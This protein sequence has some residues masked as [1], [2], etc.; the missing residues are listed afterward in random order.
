MSRLPNAQLTL[1][2]PND[3][4]DWVDPPD[5]VSDA[6]DEL[7]DRI[8]DPSGAWVD[9]ALLRGS[10]TN[11][12]QGTG[13]LVDDSDNVTAI[14]SITAA[15]SAL[16]KAGGTSGAPAS[17]LGAADLIASGGGSAGLTGGS[18]TAVGGAVNILGGAGTTRGGAVIVTGGAGG[19]VNGDGGDVVLTPGAAAGSGT[20]AEVI[21]KDHGGTEALKITNAATPVVEFN[22]DLD[23]TSQDIANA[24]IIT[25]ASTLSLLSA[26]GNNALSVTGGSNSGGTGGSVGITAGSSTGSG[27]DGGTVTLTAGG[28][29]GGGTEGRIVL[30]DHAGTDALEVT[31]DILP[32]VTCNRVLT[33]TAGIILPTTQL[34]GPDGNNNIGFVTDTSAITKINNVTALTVTGTAHDFHSLAVSNFEHVFPLVFGNSTQ[35]SADAYDQM[36]DSVAC[37]AVRGYMIPW[38]YTIVAV[39]CVVNIV[40]ATSGDVT[41]EIRI[42]DAT[43][44]T[45]E[46]QYTSAAG[47]GLK[48]LK[49]TGLSISGSADDIVSGAMVETGTMVWNN[50]QA[51]VWIKAII[52]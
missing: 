20:E 31:A 25:G 46:L 22:R 49:A 11:G 47:T 39:S 44:A 35:K 36:V 6:L 10:G 9:N 5:K 48:T 43:Q 24:R 13:I 29:H 41:H 15:G 19:L 17:V 32:K 12:I 3:P 51:V 16:L 52:A 14:G 45:A 30:V 4:A 2:Q 7:A 18:S 34:I 23:L 8:T 50:V 33:T 1:F 27:G 26:A 38:D 42:A 21:L 40:T 37:S 28:K